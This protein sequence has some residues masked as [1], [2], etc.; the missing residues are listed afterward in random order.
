MNS[1]KYPQQQFIGDKDVGIET[2]RRKLEN[3]L[4][5]VNFSLLFAVEPNCFKEVKSNEHWINEIEE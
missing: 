3:T 1:K 2:K 5:E 4:E